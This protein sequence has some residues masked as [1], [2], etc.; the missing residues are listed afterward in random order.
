M[1][2]EE[3]TQ[4]ER[5][6]EYPHGWLKN[7]NTPCDLRSLPRCQA[8]AKS[9]GERCKNPAMKGKRVCRIHGGKSPGAP[10][11]NKNALKHGF[12]TAEWIA[13][14]RATREI[15]R[16]SRAILEQLEINM[17]NEREKNEEVI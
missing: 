6:N 15:L 14:R 2:N 7:N 1:K 3:Q 17:A 5:E 10:K 13:R 11:G 8:T 12:Y 4:G 16:Q 9:T